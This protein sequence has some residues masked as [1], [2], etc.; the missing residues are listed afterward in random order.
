MYNYTVYGLSVAS[1]V[2]C[3]E[4]IAG[5]GKPDVFVRYGRL[6]NLPVTGGLPWGVHAVGNNQL[7]LNYKKTARYLVSGGNEIII[8]KF[9]E[10]D[11][12]VLRLFLLGSAF[13]AVLH[14]RGY[15]PLHGNGIL[16]N[17][18]CIAFLG[19]S[20]IG[21][22]TLAAAFVK[23]GYRLLTDDVCTIKTFP[24][25]RAMVLPGFP[26]VKLMKDA[27]HKLGE[28][29]SKLRRVRK[30]E[31]KYILPVADNHHDVPAPLKR[32]YILNIHN[33]LGF[34]F[35]KLDNIDSIKA[36]QNHTYRK[37]MLKKIGE[38]SRRFKLCGKIAGHATVKRILRPANKFMLDELVDLLEEDFR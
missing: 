12:D 5:N 27:A 13:G 4:L 35:L 17:G 6:E 15:L 2:E 23:R 36:L 37:G 33:E 16:Y 19:R 34:K 22:S 14:Q 26:H 31:E 18:E 29:T 24:D 21:K 20:G 32:V 3:P 8:D 30:E 38:T 28:D 25:G 9:S 11:D 10:A 7:M 1:E